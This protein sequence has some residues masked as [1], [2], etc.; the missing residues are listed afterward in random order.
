MSIVGS[1]AVIGPRLI[2]DDNANKQVA[3]RL[4]QVVDGLRAANPERASKV[5]I[6]TC[7]RLG[8][9]SEQPARQGQHR[10]MSQ[11]HALVPSSQALGQVDLK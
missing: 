1:L 11:S 7:R 2:V 5:A 8:A 10:P 4:H 9:G 3:I 6:V